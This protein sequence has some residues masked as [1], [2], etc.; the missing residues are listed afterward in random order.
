[1]RPSQGA[2]PEL[3]APYLT[4]RKIE[5][6][7]VPYLY[8]ALAVRLRG[9][10][11]RATPAGPSPLPASPWQETQFCTKRALPF[12][13]AAASPKTGFLPIFLTS[14]SPGKPAALSKPSAWGPV[15]ATVTA[16]VA[17][18]EGL[19]DATGLGVGVTAG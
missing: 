11:S 15:R 12:S 5:R 17:V 16:G 4:V 3:G 9:L 13:V 1:M 2:M 18:A 10:G 6:S 7:P 14:S 19:A 8:S